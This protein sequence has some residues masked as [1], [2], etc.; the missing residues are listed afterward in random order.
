LDINIGEKIKEKRLFLGL[1]LNSLG[2]KIGVT[3]TTI[4][5]WERGVIK[6]SKYE[7]I[8]ALSIALDMDI[9]E[10]LDDP[11]HSPVTIYK[12]MPENLGSDLPMHPAAAVIP[13]P[14]YSDGGID[15]VIQAMS[16]IKDIFA[17][18][19]PILI[20][21]IQANLNAFK[22]ALLREQQFLQVMQ[23]NKELKERISRLE[24]LCDRIPELE[25]RIESLQ[26]ENESL[27]TEVTQGKVES[28]ALRIEI[29]RLKATYEAPDGGSGSLTN[30]SG[31]E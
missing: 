21:A 7:K 15:P 10:L 25:V 13:A 27:R 31:N 23:E 2:A 20:P 28:K 14:A 17:S 9:T 24:A 22:R 29:N 30:M 8:R 18:G 4:Q 12:N 6:P 3:G 19:D 26:A 5:K 1:S 16:D 11:S